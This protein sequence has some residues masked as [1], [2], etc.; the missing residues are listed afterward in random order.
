MLTFNDQPLPCPRGLTLA[1][2]LESQGVD[3]T[4]VATAVNGHF[5]PRAQRAATILQ[6]H[7]R[8]LTFQAI[9][10]G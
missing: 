6:P 4:A 5:V 7:D 9:V 10:G 8:V 3:G 2:L 1:Q